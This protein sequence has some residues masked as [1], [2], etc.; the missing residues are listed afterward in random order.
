[1]QVRRVVESKSAEIGEDDVVPHLVPLK[2]R[3][4]MFKEVEDLR[5]RNAGRACA[6][7]R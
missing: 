5:R 2:R 3:P 1:M 4:V 7:S 6:R